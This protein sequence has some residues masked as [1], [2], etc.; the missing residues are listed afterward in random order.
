MHIAGSSKVKDKD[1]VWGTVVP[2]S[3][4]LSGNAAQVAVQTESGQ[5]VLV[6]TDIF[7]QQ[8][9]GS[10]YLPLR[11][12]ELEDTGSEHGGHQDE[13]MVVPVLVEEL[14]VQKRLVKTGKVRITKV[15][16]ERETLV[17]EPLSHDKVAITR[18]P[19][20]RVV[21]GLVPIREENGTTII[22]VV[23]EV[24]VVEKRLMLR[25]E[26][27]IRKQRIETHQPQRITLHSEEVQVERV[28]QTDEDK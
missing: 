10:Y 13:P 27:H 28:P 17:D 18:V 25:E 15:V 6:P 2:E 11:L 1:G 19:I 9:D 16:R 8:P 20:Q 26:I 14:D 23:E 7:I 24:L 4:H 3:P 22:S 21:D 12:V 5:Q